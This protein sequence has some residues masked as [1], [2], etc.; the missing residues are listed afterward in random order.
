MAKKL[1]IRNSTA[2]FLTF[3][4]E[5]KEDGV[6]VAYRD[7]TIWATQKAMAQL[8]DV[9]VPAIN[10]HLNNI[11]SDGELSQS[12]TISKMEIVQMEGIREVTRQVDFYNL[13]AISD[14]DIFNNS[15]LLPL[16]IE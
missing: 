4:L 3:I 6:Q 7:E 13:D 15:Y 8:F 2:E 1:E 10:K 14:F 12:S 5:G 11:Y 9:G 16:N